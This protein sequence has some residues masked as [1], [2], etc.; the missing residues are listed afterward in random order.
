MLDLAVLLGSDLP[1]STKNPKIVDKAERDEN[2]ESDI[3]IIEVKL[4][5][6]KKL[7]QFSEVFGNESP[8]VKYTRTLAT[9]PF[10]HTQVS[11]VG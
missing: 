3:Q 6:P 4:A 2:I 7:G 10:S 9:Q 1:Q 5:A 11:Y 8:P